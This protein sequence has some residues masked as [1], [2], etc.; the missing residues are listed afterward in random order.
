M[1]KIGNRLK[2]LRSDRGISLRELAR[3]SNVSPSFLSQIENG[4]SQPSVATLFTIAQQLEVP[5]DTLFESDNSSSAVEIKTSSSTDSEHDHRSALT[6]PADV[7]QASAYAN[8]ISVIHSSHR[9][10]LDVSEGV[11]WE[12]LAATP[13][14]SVNFMK[15][16]Y[17]PGAY[18]TESGELLTHSGYEYGYVLE[19]EFEVTVGGEVFVIQAGESIGFDSTIPHIF[20]NPG[21]IPAVG[22]WTIHGTCLAT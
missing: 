1:N 10:K 19:G 22:I 6:N 17:A 20:R 11:K 18:S 12:R 5:I 9:A 16:T 2:D 7:W 21:D 8:R 3:L 15:I 13:E 4:K 14:R